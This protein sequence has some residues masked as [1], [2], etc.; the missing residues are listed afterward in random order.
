MHE[1]DSQEDPT[2]SPAI[3]AAGGNHPYAIFRNAEFVRYLVARFVAAL[4]MQMMITALDWELYKRTRS[5]IGR[6]HV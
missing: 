1:T 2:L 4:G 6:A 3:P 5:E